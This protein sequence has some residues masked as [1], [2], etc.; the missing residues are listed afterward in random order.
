MTTFRYIVGGNGFTGA[1]TGVRSVELE[2]WGGFNVYVEFSVRRRTS[3]LVSLAA[4]DAAF[5]TPTY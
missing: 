1:L 3:V 2:E 4:C 5:E